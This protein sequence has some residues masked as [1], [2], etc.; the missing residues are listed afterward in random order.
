[1]LKIKKKTGRIIALVSTIRLKSE[2][3]IDSFNY[4]SV[5]VMLTFKKQLN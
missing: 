1:M 3:H 5:I 2:D 4:K